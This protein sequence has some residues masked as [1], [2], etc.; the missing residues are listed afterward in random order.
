MLS[1]VMAM[2]FSTIYERQ[3]IQ[4]VPENVEFDAFLGNSKEAL[5]D[6][7]SKGELVF[8]I[9]VKNTG[10]LKNVSIISILV[11][12]KHYNEMVDYKIMNWP[13]K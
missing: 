7:N 8:N 12:L 3:T 11:F 5:L 1:P 10:Y 4:I 9:K 6:I 2:S 13:T